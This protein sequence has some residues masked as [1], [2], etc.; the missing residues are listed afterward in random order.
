VISIQEC[1]LM[2]NVSVAA[3]AQ[4]AVQKSYLHWTAAV[5][6][7][8]YQMW[9]KTDGELLPRTLIVYTNSFL[10]TDVSDHAR[11]TFVRS[12]TSLPLCFPLFCRV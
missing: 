7:P 12:Y 8:A 10:L 3:G 2:G 4:F 5:G 11:V 9:I 1:M 6:A